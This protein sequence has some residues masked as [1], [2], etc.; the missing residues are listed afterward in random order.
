MVRGAITGYTMFSLGSKVKSSNALSSFNGVPK[1]G[2]LNGGDIFMGSM[3]K[4]Q[5]WGN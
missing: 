4:S 2:Y 1:D 3:L 5:G